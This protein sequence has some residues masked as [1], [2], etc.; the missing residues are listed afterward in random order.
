MN[1]GLV[2]NFTR[3]RKELLMLF[4]FIILF[5][6]DGAF[7]FFPSSA[8]KGLAFSPSLFYF[9]FYLFIFGL[10]EREREREGR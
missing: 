10:G 1:S 2:C 3:G 7:P 9:L 5:F 4:V 8:G 6:A